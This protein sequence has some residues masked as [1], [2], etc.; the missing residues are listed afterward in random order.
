[1]R[2]AAGSTKKVVALCSELP[3][4]MVEP[5]GGRLRGGDGEE[6]ARLRWRKEEKGHYSNF[7]LLVYHMK[8]KSL[9]S[10]LFMKLK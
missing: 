9:L 4:V 8:V 3:A 1:M 10:E 6:N 5:C 7:I 2:A